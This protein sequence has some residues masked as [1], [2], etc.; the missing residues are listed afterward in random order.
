MAGF[1]ITLQTFVGDAYTFRGGYTGSTVIKSPKLIV[2]FRD[3]DVERVDDRF[4]YCNEPLIDE[5][6]KAQ[7]NA[8]KD[9]Q[10]EVFQIYR[11]AI[12]YRTKDPIVVQKDERDFTIS[13]IATDGI[14]ELP[15]FWRFLCENYQKKEL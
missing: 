5:A 4:Y 11:N 6:A 2:Y 1:C 14:T 12:E 10:R 3:E 9:A 8:S 7:I 15:L 13:I